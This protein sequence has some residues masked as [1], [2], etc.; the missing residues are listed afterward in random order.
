M[1]LRPFLIGLLVCLA[2]SLSAEPVFVRSGEHD[3][4]SRLVFEF[5]GQIN[6]SATVS[7]C[8]QRAYIFSEQELDGVRFVGLHGY[9][10]QRGASRESYPIVSS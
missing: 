2:G 3:G 5:R 6:S 9:M 8:A 4:F 1:I 10:Q 7:A